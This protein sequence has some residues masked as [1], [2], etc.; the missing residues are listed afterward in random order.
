LHAR[1]DARR[2][3]IELVTLERVQALSDSTG[4]A[5]PRYAEGLRDAARAAIGYCLDALV[6]GDDR[7]PPIPLELVAQARL[8]ARCGVSLDTVLRRCCAG[9]ALLGDFVV[10]EADEAGISGTDL[11]WTLRGHTTLLDRLLATVSEE[12]LREQRLEETRTSER[13]RVGLCRRLLDGELIDT[14]SLAYDFDGFHIGIVGRGLVDVEP[15]HVLAASLNRRLVL[16]RPDELTVWAWLGGR[17]RVDPAELDEVVSSTAPA[18]GVQAFGEEAEGLTGWRLTHRQAA[19]AG[20]VAR[21]E[22]RSLVRYADVALLASVAQDE[23]L[24]A[25]LRQLYLE[26]L[27]RGA[28]DGEVVKETLRAYFEADRNISSAAAALGAN[29]STVASRLRAIEGR[30]GR[31]LHACAAE[32]E[33]ALCLERL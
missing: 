31:R 6:A 20:S 5:D 32:L 33:A 19:A 10:E 21:P 3:E 8:A 7:T 28:G 17:R 25:S 16:V 4:V 23:V 11:K 24:A 18:E 22:R 29:R 26:P 12:Y 27:E 30:I 2:G 13:Q 9:H 14:S 1:L 15:L